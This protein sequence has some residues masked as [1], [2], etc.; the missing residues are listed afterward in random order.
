MSPSHRT[1]VA[2]ASM[3]RPLTLYRIRVYDDGGRAFMVR[4]YVQRPAVER[5]VTYWNRRGCHVTVEITE[6]PVQFLLVQ[7]EM[8]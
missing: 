4:F 3:S 7:G 6:R 5:Q 8:P 2:G 1:S